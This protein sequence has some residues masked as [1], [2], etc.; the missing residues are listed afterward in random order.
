MNDCIFCKIIKRE[1]PCNKI[2][3]DKDIFAFLDNNP[4]NKGHT[5]IIPKKH[6][7]N[8][9][10]TPDKIISK[11]II[12]AKKLSII[13]KKTMKSDGINVYMNN[14]RA[15]GQQV[16]HAHIHVIPRLEKDGFTYWKNKKKYSDEEMSEIKNKINSIL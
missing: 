9:Y 8:I 12:G 3:E 13:I 10:E 11:M 1:I 14:G 4:V 6:L 16:E 15:A 5:L 7:E 2:Y